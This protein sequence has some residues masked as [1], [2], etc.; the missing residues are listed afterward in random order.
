MNSFRS[1]AKFS[2][3]CFDYC[4]YNRCILVG[5]LLHLRDRFRLFLVTTHETLF[6]RID[7]GDNGKIRISCNVQPTLFIEIC[8]CM[9]ERHRCLRN[10]DGILFAE[11]NANN[12]KYDQVNWVKLSIII[13]LVTWQ[14]WLDSTVMSLDYY[15]SIVKVCNKSANI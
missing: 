10:F 8:I 5:T 11:L 4:I 14:I 13:C 12:K 1:F 15:G 3:R 6:L 9:I 2:N 7:V